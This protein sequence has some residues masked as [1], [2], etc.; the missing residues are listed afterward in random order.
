MENTGRIKSYILSEISDILYST[1]SEDQI[2]RELDTTTKIN[3]AHI[4]MLAERGCIEQKEAEK[5]LTA[6]SEMR[7]ER[8]A[9]VL[10]QPLRRGLY[11]AYESVLI[12]K[13]GLDTGGLLQYGRSRN[14]LK[15][16]VLKMQLREPLI[17]LYSRLIEFVELLLEKSR[18]YNHAIM[19]AYTHYQPAV[20]ITYGHYLMGVAQCFSRSMKPLDTILD[21]LGSCPLGAGAVG[22]TTVRIDSDRTAYLLGFDNGV[23]N[24]V[25]AVASRDYVLRILAELTVLECNITRICEDF[26]LWTSSDF[27]FIDMP[28]CM[29]GGSS[30]MPNKRNVFVLENIR[31]RA[32]ASSGAF[33]SAVNAM[34]GA[35]FS[36]S[37][38]VGTEGVSFVWKPLK[39]CA[40][41]L[42]LIG[43][44]I[45]HGTPNEK[46]MRKRAVSGYTLA[47]EQ[48]NYIVYNTNHSF[49]DAH[50]IV[51]E[52]ITRSEENGSDYASAFTLWAKENLG[53][54]PYE[55]ITSINDSFLDAANYGGGPGLNSW[56]AQ[57]CQLTVTV[58]SLKE[59]L[60][61]KTARYANADRR[62]EDAVA[63]FFKRGGP[64]E[65]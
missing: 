62:L 3:N 35:P 20:P 51:G 61:N 37:I 26:L 42:F 28:D 54:E 53:R 44:V 38:A 34:N 52:M 56:N 9:E 24:S 12:G 5:L 6:I 33:I 4:L 11:L 18:E 39:S 29:V 41:N 47:T 8:Y 65:S 15:A 50:R 30:M 58:S 43:C 23:S 32:A 64:H 31:G 1:E 57:N 17:S 10:R 49:R 2:V 55:G 22:G 46:I 60:N 13:V 40:E 21:E 19:P 36:N 45:R 16:T 7:D 63:Q 14:D 48:A 25:D 27:G 59:H